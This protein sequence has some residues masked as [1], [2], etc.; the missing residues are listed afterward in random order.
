MARVCLTLNVP[1]PSRGY[2]AK[3]AA[4]KVPP[5][6]PFPDA[7]P[8]DPLEWPKD[9]KHPAQRFCNPTILKRSSQSEGAEMVGQHILLRGTRELYLDSRSQKGTE[10]LKPKKKNLP[11]ITSSEQRLDWAMAFANALYTALDR[12]GC[13]TI[14]APTMRGSFATT[15]TSMK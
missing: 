1:C 5:P 10:H 4:G 8:G 14:L 11:D 15:L 13:R 3:L 2:W 7:R 6:E 9:T 12:A